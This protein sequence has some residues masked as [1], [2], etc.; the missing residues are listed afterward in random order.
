MASA[1]DRGAGPTSRVVNGP[2]G[3]RNPSA[4]VTRNRHMG[5]RK[6][7]L[8]LWEAGNTLCPICL[9][10]FSK[11]DVIAKN[12]RA[13]IEHIPPLKAGKPYIRVLTCKNCNSEGGKWID[14]AM[15]ELIKQEHAVALQIGTGVYAMRAGLNRPA[16]TKQCITMTHPAVADP[17]YMW[18]ARNQQVPPL[19]RQTLRL[20]SYQRRKSEI[21]LLKAAYLSVFSL[22][23]VEFAKANALIE[24]R[25]QIAQPDADILRNF[26]LVGEETGRGIYIVYTK[27]RTCWGIAIDGY[28]VF[29]PSADSDEW[30][31]AL[32]DVRRSSALKKFTHS[33]GADRRFLFQPLHKV[34]VESLT[35]DVRRGLSQL[36]SLG[37]EMRATSD[38]RILGNF[39]SVGRDQD[40]LWFLECS[41]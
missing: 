40:S 18:P 2:S 6:T 33:F 32:D 27:G 14:H 13:S 10:E 22:L 17:I 3:S 23:G 1:P 39:V 37:W 28:W 41:R 38:K 15:V 34:P 25:R 4:G 7:R 29:L 21:G 20:I 31:P 30:R 11:E 9:L 19:P 8:S 35:D 24:V 16:Q 12:G 5:K 36:G 26:C